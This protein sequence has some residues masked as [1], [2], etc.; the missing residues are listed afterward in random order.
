LTIENN[1]ARMIGMEQKHT[2]IKTPPKGFYLGKRE[3]AVQRY[4]RIKALADRF[5][6]GNSSKF[7]QMVADGELLVVDPKSD[8]QPA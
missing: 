8:K 2:S 5:A 4:Q 3:K 7:I 1:L 6:D